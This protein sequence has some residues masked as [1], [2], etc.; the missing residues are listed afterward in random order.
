M[1]PKIKSRQT[2][3]MTE[4]LWDLWCFL[5]I[6]GIWPRFI[7]P[8]IIKTQ[9]I[10]LSI[11]HLPLGLSKLR[12]VHFSDLHF[13]PRLPQHF[14]Q[15]LLNNIEKLQPDLIVFT[16]DFICYS[17]LDE[18][19]R[20]AQFLT[21]VKNLAPLGVWSVLGNHDYS[22]FASINEEGIYALVDKNPETI[23]RALK[24]LWNP[25][26]VPKQAQKLDVYPHANLVNLIQASGWNLLHNQT[27]QLSLPQGRL[28]ICG[29]GEYMMGDVDIEATFKNYDHNT[30]GIILLHNPDAI[31][32]LT[33]QP[34]GLILSGHTHGGQVNLPWIRKR[35]SLMQYPEY[36][37]GLIPFENK[38]VYVTRG[39][40]SV[41]PFRWFAPPEIV[42]IELNRA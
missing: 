35:F 24:R 29:F 30:A 31:P 12:I 26:Q 28:N 33:N 32:L 8:Y 4:R 13:Y 38:W 27:Q 9:S 19:D 25:P 5:S 1:N 22:Q 20:L 14:L 37:H 39:V 40:G 34:G 15:R 42:L 10:K 7:E 16:G 41:L 6:I 17:H 18:P 23:T 2:S 3:S 36:K 11:P 21:S